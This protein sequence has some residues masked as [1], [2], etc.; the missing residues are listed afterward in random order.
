MPEQKKKILVVEDDKAVSQVMQLK[1]SRDGF[2]VEVAE[3]GEIALENLKN[4]KYDLILLDLIMP[5]VNGF[6]LLK[7]LHELH[8][9]TPKI[10][11]SNLEQEEDIGKVKGLGAVELLPKFEMSLTGIADYVKNYLTR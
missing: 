11:M 7:N 8:S 4:K 1:L 2:E 5:K 10:V 6:E 9:T 3:N